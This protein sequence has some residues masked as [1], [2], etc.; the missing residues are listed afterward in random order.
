M[1]WKELMKNKIKNISIIIPVLNEEE[2]IENL[3]DEI[4]TN[5]YNKIGYEVVV[6]DDGST[7]G[8][9]KKIKKILKNH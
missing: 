7:D 9:I 1:K 4:K 5:L 2:N 6:V 3:L 8:T